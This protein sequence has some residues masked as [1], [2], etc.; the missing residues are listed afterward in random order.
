MSLYAH[1]CRRDAFHIWNVS[2]FI[3]VHV[4]F[5]YGEMYATMHAAMYVDVSQHTF[6][7]TCPYMSHC[8]L[9][10]ME[11]YGAYMLPCINM[12][13]TRY[14]TIHSNIWRHICSLI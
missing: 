6:A 7:L 4:C 13:F 3:H 14:A 1:I 11:K 5:I 12:Y 2:F 8:M 10:Y 9:P